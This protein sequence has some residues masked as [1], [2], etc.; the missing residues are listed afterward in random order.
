[1]L[2]VFVGFGLG[3]DFVSR[4]LPHQTMHGCIQRGVQTT[5]LSLQFMVVLCFLCLSSQWMFYIDGLSNG[6]PLRFRLNCLNYLLL[7]SAVYE[8]NTK[9]IRVCT[10]QRDVLQGCYLW[11]HIDPV[12]LLPNQSGSGTL[13]EPGSHS[14][15]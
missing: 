1:M 3:V 5:S 11:S 9:S 8:C 6:P 15:K 13:I 7:F 14:Y 10:T 12:G 4:E 2:C